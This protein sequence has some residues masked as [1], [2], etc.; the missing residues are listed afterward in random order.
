MVE[1]IGDICEPS[2]LTAPTHET[3]A[4]GSGISG[5]YLFLSGGKLL[6][7]TGAGAFETVT[8]S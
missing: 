3:I 4:N 5:G 8:S 7:D 1:I 6:F 2:D